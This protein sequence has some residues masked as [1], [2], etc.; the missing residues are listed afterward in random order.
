MKSKE[1]K[2]RKT[3]ELYERLG[4]RYIENV[5]GVTIKEFPD[6][7][8]LL[9]KCGRVL[10]VGC[11]AGRDSL[12]FVQE[13]FEVVGIDLVDVFLKEARKSVPQAKFLKMDLLE[14][15][16]SKD[17]F[18]AIW[19]NA[20]LLHIAKKDIPNALKGFYRVLKPGGKLHIGVKRGKGEKYKEEWL[21]GGEKRFFAYFFKNELEKFVKEAG[22]KI[23]SSKIFPD[24][25]GRKDTK[26]IGILAEK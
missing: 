21:S 3:I 2:Y 23:I 20:V 11:T 15:N 14:L 26:W 18:D 1:D 9:P 5:A 19:A 8:K 10:D 6:F 13:G 24:E 7:V 12:K 17:H 22:F 16:F 4:K 25:L